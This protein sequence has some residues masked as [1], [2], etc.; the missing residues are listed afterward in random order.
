M[1]EEYETQ[2]DDQLEPDLC[3]KKLDIVDEQI[4]YNELDHLK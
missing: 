1:T 3:K 2:E 4:Y